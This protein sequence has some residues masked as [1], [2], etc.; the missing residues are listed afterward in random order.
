MNLLS[1]LGRAKRIVLGQK[2]EVK[3][4]SAPA[5]VA[6]SLSSIDLIGRILGS[7]NSVVAVDVGGANNLQPHWWRLVG[8]AKFIVYEPHDQSYRELLERQ[9]ADPVYRDFRYMNEALSESGG[10]RILYQTNVP[11]GS[12]LSPPKK[13]GMG[14]YCRNTYFWP[15]TEKL[16]Q[17]STLTDS[18][19]REMIGYIDVIK[20]DTQGTE[21]E[22][23]RGLNRERLS[24]TLLIE[25]ECSVLDI[26]EG[27]ERVLED[28]LHFMRENDFAL[29]DLRTNRFL[30]NSVRLDPE[31]LKQRL[32]SELELP[33]IAHRL[34]E[35][36]A[37][38]ARDPKFLIANGADAGLLRRFV[39][40]LVTYNLFAEAVFTVIAG[41]DSGTFRDS[42]AEELL[43]WI[44]NLKMLAGSGLETVIDQIRAA[45]GL[46]WAQ[47]MW[48]PHPSA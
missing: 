24:R 31:V 44:S 29:F 48:V 7:D 5:T 20:L 39:A 19:D 6:T 28:M 16:I 41:R 10:Q 46:T 25:A 42:E 26:Y 22:I 4:R 12:S 27:G 8:N 40:I 36:D 1:L 17:T 47:Y 21:L 38:F 34:A 32:G 11:T 43:Q 14:D 33:P 9:A 3:S 30:G 18:L 23:L 13:G 45:G 15:L 37:V 35:V 2:I